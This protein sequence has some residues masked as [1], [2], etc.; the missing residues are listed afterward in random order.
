MLSRKL[1][2]MI[3]ALSLLIC[4]VPVQAD[5]PVQ[6]EGITVPVIDDI[7]TYEIPDNDAMATLRDMKCGWN[8]GNTFD[9]FSNYTQ[10]VTG[11]DMDSS[12]VGSKT[13]K[14]LIET[15]QEAGFNTIHSRSIT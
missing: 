11:T 1:F 6:T 7:K 2:A 3:I 9:A 14:K 12:W 15:I 5:V 8:L 10:R 4:A 13:R